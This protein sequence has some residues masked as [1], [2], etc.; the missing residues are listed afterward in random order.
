MDIGFPARGPFTFHSPDFGVIKMEALFMSPPPQRGH[1]ATK[2]LRFSENLKSIAQAQ[3]E[4]LAPQ[5]A[6]HMLMRLSFMLS[7]VRQDFD[8]PTS[9][10][11]G[12]HGYCTQVRRQWG[13][14]RGSQV[15]LPVLSYFL[16]SSSQTLC[17]SSF[18]EPASGLHCYGAPGRKLSLFSTLSTLPAYW[19]S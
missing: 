2:M 15:A 10:L 8:V 7:S 13:P 19:Y 9:H 14:Q 3:R 1:N 5:C 4:P 6:A 12:A 17:R 16:C 18:R 11:I